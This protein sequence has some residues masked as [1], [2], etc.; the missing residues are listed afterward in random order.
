M[1]KS[2]SGALELFLSGVLGLGFVTGFWPFTLPLYLAL[3]FGFLTAVGAMLFV[4]A[5]SRDGK[6]PVRIVTMLGLFGGLSFLV[7][8]GTM[9]YFTSYLPTVPNLFNFRLGK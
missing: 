8:F 6:S 5:M 7:M 4:V 1:S 3:L 9:W 2:S